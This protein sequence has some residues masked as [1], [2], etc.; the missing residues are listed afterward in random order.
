MLKEN[1][2]EIDTI[3]SLTNRIVETVHP[4]K[5]ILFGSFARGEDTEKSDYD[6]YIIDDD[7]DADNFRLKWKK[8][9]KAL[10]K[11]FKRD[12]DLIFNTNKGFLENKTSKSNVSFYVDKEGVTLY[13][14]F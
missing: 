6:F 11:F 1:V 13:E 10:L 14:H 8:T 2:N 3:M 4:Q 7:T 9:K 5:V 12:I